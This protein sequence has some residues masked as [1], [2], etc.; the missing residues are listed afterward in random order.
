MRQALN[1]C[2]LVVDRNL[3]MSSLLQLTFL[4]PLLDW[5]EE[6]NSTAGGFAEGLLDL[7]RLATAGHSRGGKLATLHFA[8]ALRPCARTCVDLHLPEDPCIYGRCSV[9][10]ADRC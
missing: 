3:C 4:S 7:T 8:S 9:I 6:Q 2:T 1:C 10:A 5:L